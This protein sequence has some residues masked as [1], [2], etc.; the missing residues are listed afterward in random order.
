MMN[1]SWQE[2]GGAEISCAGPDRLISGQHTAVVSG[3]VDVWTSPVQFRQA[4][5]HRL[6]LKPLNP[7]PSPLNIP[8]ISNWFALCPLRF[9]MAALESTQFVQIC[10]P[11]I[12]P[13]ILQQKYSLAF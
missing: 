7:P 10:I 13:A 5:A 2:P 8:H 4:G 1:E 11:P 3:K 9:V 12:K 6:P